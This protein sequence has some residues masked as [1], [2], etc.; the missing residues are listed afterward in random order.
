MT[1]E[2]RWRQLP[3]ADILDAA[4]RLH[5]YTDEGQAIIQAELQRRGLAPG[6]VPEAA[7]PPERPRCQSCGAALRPDDAFCASCGAPAIGATPR[8]AAGRPDSGPVIWRTNVLLMVVLTIATLG[9]YY[10]YWFL[11]RRPLLNMLRSPERV[12][13]WPFACAIVL[14]VANAAIALRTPG[15]AE[16]TADPLALL[17]ELAFG[18]TLLVQCFKVRRMLASHLGDRVP[19]PGQRTPPEAWAATLSS[20]AVFFFGIFY[21]QHIINTRFPNERIHIVPE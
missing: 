17:V 14:L 3:D 8:I 18:L 15:P 21:L 10:P 1:S 9:V 20:M 7:P 13:V 19:P 2:R 6:A 11:S 16:G 5:D 4:R 12:E